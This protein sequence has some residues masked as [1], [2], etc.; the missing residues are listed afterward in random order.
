MCI[1]AHY[2]LINKCFHLHKEPDSQTS[3]ITGSH[4][5]VLHLSHQED[6]QIWHAIRSMVIIPA[7]LASQVVNDK[8]P[9]VPSTPKHLNGKFPLVPPIPRHLNCTSMD[10]MTPCPQPKM[11]QIHCLTSIMLCK[12]VIQHLTVGMSCMRHLNLALY[13]CLISMPVLL[14]HNDLW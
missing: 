7:L 12:Q 2:Y 9:L 5:M 1:P 10:M 14:Q 11:Q 3:F 6:H 8:F 4:N 13:P